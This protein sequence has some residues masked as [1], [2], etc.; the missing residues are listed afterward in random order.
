M[1]KSNRINCF[2]VLV[3]FFISCG[4]NSTKTDNKSVD[5]NDF[6]R[7][8]NNF[9]PLTLDNFQLLGEKFNKIYLANEDSLNKVESI[10]QKNFLSNMDPEYL[11]YGF[12][13]V[14]PNKS[15]VLTV[16]NHYGESKMRDNGEVIDTTFFTSIVY[17]DLGKPLCSFRT[18][19]SNL[20]GE[21]PTYNM[22]STFEIENNKLVITNYEYSTGK[23]YA[24]A[25]LITGSDSIYLADLTISK[26]SLN[27]TTN[28]IDFINRLKR[29]A[30]VVETCCDPPTYLK[31]IN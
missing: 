3:L 1:K 12:K 16:E 6:V 22:T 13:T 11:Y 4:H 21:P 19:G 18:F 25:N 2:C 20:T 15:I 17:S 29:K 26:Y 7:F 27:Y 30:K 10:Y 8:Q 28:K 24:K 31:P 23:S 14:L 9:K 5:N